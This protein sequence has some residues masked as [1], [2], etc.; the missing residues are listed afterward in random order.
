MFRY[1]ARKGF[2]AI[3]LTVLF[4]LLLSSSFLTSVPT[5]SALGLHHRDRTLGTAAADRH[6][7]FGTAVVSNLLGTTPYTTVLDTQFSGVTPGNEM[8]WETTEPTRGTFNFGPADTIV[9]HALSHGMK[10]RGHTLVW[11]NQLA[12][13][14]STI[15]DGADLLR[16][17][18]NHITTEVSHFRGKLW[19][20]D[21]V[22]EAFNEDGTLRSDIFENEIGDSY[23]ADAFK[24]AHAAD[25]RV[26]LCYNDYNIEGINAKSDAVYAM[27]KNFKAHGVPINCVG[28]QSHL[29]VGLVPSDMRANLERFARLGVDVQ[30]TELDI[31]M[32]TPA[33]D[34]NLQQQAVDYTSVVNACLAVFRCNDITTWGIGDADSWI[35]AFFQGQGAALLF[36]TNY[37]KKAAYFAVMHALKDKH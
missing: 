18:K 3:P 11:H 6:R 35:P 15:T 27:V 14:V 19:Y 1:L 34:A 25:P 28:F 7:I 30:I 9:N 24:A 17:L 36:D 8:K 26:K 37:D 31:R 5:V 32:P 12:P 20:W 21:V 22:N 16:A 29:I 33:S 13:W 10:V 23:I 2:F 4:T